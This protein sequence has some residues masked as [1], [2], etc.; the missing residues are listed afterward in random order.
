HSNSTCARN[1]SGN[2]FAQL[3]ET[4][5]RSVFRPAFVQRAFARFDDVSR[6]RKIRFTDLQMNNVFPLL[7]KS[8]GFD[9]DFKCGFGPDTGHLFGKLHR[10]TVLPDQSFYAMPFMKLAGATSR[11]WRR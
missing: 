1:V 3:R 7:F 2:A 5:G 6:R 11:C 4:S 9:K 10:P 8:A